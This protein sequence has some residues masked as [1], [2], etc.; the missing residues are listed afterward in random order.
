[1]IPQQRQAAFIERYSIIPDP[2]DRLAAIVA[3]RPTTGPLPPEE[4]TPD[5]LVPGCQSRVWIAASV[6]PDSGRCRFRMHAES[7]LV[8]G[9]IGL[10][11][12]LYD[13]APPEEIAAV[14]PE[15]FERLGIA[16]NL[17]PTR[18][19]GLAAVR[20]FLREFAK[21]QLHTE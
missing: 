19:N 20:A 17:T 11:C 3:R 2:Q 15:I 10:L 9:L 12:D 16:R 5:L 4:Q 13:D 8:R 21:R 1:M 14:E 7:A 18:L 6:S